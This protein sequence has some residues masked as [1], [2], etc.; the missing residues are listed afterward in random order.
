MKK[1]T[2]LFIFVFLM[3]FTSCGK[4]NKYVLIET[5]Y[6]NIKVR[7]YKETPEHQKNFI[8]LVKQGY[9]DE[10]LFHRVIQNFM[11]QGGDP[12]SKNAQPGVRLGEGEPGYTISAEINQQLFHKRGALSA[13]RQSDEINP[14]KR[15]SGSQ[16]F[17]VQGEPFTKEALDAM[18]QS[19]NSERVQRIFIRLFNENKEEI[20]QLRK[21]GDREKFNARIDELQEK[22]ETEAKQAGDSIFSPEQIEAYTTIGGCPSLDGEYTVFGEV[23]EGLN[24]IDKI[25]AEAT[26][27]YD[28]PEKDI[29]F[30]VTVVKK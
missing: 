8:K 23:V 30:K 2:F 25:A 1:I 17:I 11:I 10:Q 19:K 3:I 5:S 6:G 13:A 28:R 27:H 16:F 26:D 12:K 15:S 18:Q 7:L 20:T 22:A 29:K 14:E 24:V 21:S 4:P 9:F